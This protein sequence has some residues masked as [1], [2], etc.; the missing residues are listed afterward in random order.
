MDYTS[1]FRS[2]SDRR[3]IDTIDQPSDWADD[4][5]KAARVELARRGLSEDEINELRGERRMKENARRD[6]QVKLD[7][8]AADA[9]ATMGELHESLVVPSDRMPSDIRQR[10]FMLIP[11]AFMWLAVMPRYL[12]LPWLLDGDFD[13]STLEHFLP[14][15]L[16]PLTLYLIWQSRRA[17]W[18]LGAA[19]TIYSLTVGAIMA[20]MDW[21]RRPAGGGALEDLFPVPSSSELLAGL[22]FAAGF[23]WVF[24]LRRSVDML[25]ITE[26]ER[27]LT[28]IATLLLTRWLVA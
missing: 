1:L 6:R 25:R 17:G 21:G 10:M 7:R 5:V 11:I 20:A 12:H 23:A 8:L 9:K 27:W 15:F 28:I 2:V 13:I 18:F 16:L 19:I 14:L 24:Q 3:L 4:A 22:I 26:R